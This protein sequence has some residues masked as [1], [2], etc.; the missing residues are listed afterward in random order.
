MFVPTSSN[1]LYGHC[2]LAYRDI[3]SHKAALVALNSYTNEMKY[4]ILT[5]S[6]ESQEQ[7]QWM[8]IKMDD[9][10]KMN[11]CG[12]RMILFGEEDRYLMITYAYDV[13]VYDLRNHTWV[14]VF[15]NVLWG[16]SLCSWL[17]HGLV[18]VSKRCK[19]LNE[20]YS[21]VILTMHCSSYI[22]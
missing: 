5:S 1:T 8:D 6:V 19:I 14:N 17:Y 22:I 13:Y 21:W 9:R 2:V 7:E 11:K 15:R 3:R 4:M 20:K 16:P 10:I 12:A 18:H